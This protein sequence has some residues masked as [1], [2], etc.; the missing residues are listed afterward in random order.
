MSENH[1]DWL[2][3]VSQEEANGTSVSIKPEGVDPKGDEAADHVGGDEKSTAQG[4]DNAKNH[5]IDIEEGMEPD[6]NADA[7]KADGEIGVK[8]VSKE[9]GDSPDFRIDLQT[10][11]PAGGKAST[12]DGEQEE[13]ADADA[14]AAAPADGADADTPAEGD[15]APAEG[16]D[17]PAEGEAAPVEGEAAQLPAEGEGEG[18]PAEGDLGVDGT[19]NTGAEEGEGVATLT[20]AADGAAPAEGG[21]G[22]GTIPVPIDPVTEIKEGTDAAVAEAEANPEGTDAG[23]PAEGEVPA[24]GDGETVSQE[25]FGGGLLG[26]LT[27]TLG[28]APFVGAGVN[29]AAKTARLKLQQDIEKIAKRIADVRKGDIEDAKKNGTKVPKNLDNFDFVTVLKSAL[30]GQFFGPFYGAHQGSQL[31]NLNNELQ[32]KLKELKA[33]LDKAGIDPAGAST[34]DFAEDQG[35]QQDT[36]FD[37]EA[38]EGIMQPVED[39]LGDVEDI[40]AMQVAVENYTEILNEVTARG[41]AVD[42][43]LARSIQIG[44]RSFKGENL[45]AGQPSV[46]DF[47]DGANQFTVSQELMDDLKGKGAAIGEA[48]VNAVKKLLQI[49]ADTVS[50]IR[51]NAP[52]LKQK[53]DELLKRASG[54][55][56][57]ANGKIPVG[58]AARLFIGN[59]F[60]GDKAGNYADLQ[61]YADK[62]LVDYPKYWNGV[63]QKLWQLFEANDAAAKIDLGDIA[64]LIGN[65]YQPGMFGLTQTNDVPNGDRYDNNFASPTLLGNRKVVVHLSKAAERNGVSALTD[66]FSVELASMPS[67]GGESIEVMLPDGQ[68]I[69]QILTTLDKLIAQVPNYAE[70]GKKLANNQNITKV[71]THK[72]LIGAAGE[73]GA[74]SLAASMTKPTGAM[75]GHVV[76]TIK[77]AHKFLE[78]CISQHEGAA[79]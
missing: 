51:N 52:A 59:N 34:E 11:G 62:F 72:W 73:H 2:T 3:R 42:P 74:S 24:E 64:Q 33:E 38:D 53:N 67:G 71:L 26:F 25:G 78:H 43:L 45:T 13:S 8:N 44:L 31:Q 57:Q 4:S 7:K 47:K 18:A 61:K 35:L 70:A 68:S 69:R 49:L 16:A 50:E 14:E 65:G 12:E 27:G 79:Q 46:E 22:E 5:E 75:V 48:M 32:S 6:D 41:Q 1:L 66:V 63:V 29:A 19:E 10:G 58:G 76:N 40:G 39:T 17:A 20:G 9:S 60:A 15:V 21:E 23:V 30:L 37:G 77:V 36:E 55:K 56:G 54:L 28:W